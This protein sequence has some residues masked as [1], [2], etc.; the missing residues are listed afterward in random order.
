VIPA[1]D[2]S[3]A[4]RVPRRPDAPLQTPAP[5]RF[6]LP[7]K[8]GQGDE[9]ATSATP[10]LNTPR[11]AA[12]TPRREARQQQQ[13][14]VPAFSTPATA[15]SRP[16]P[17]RQW[18]SDAIDDTSPQSSQIL[19]VH[20]SEDD[21]IE[22]DSQSQA[23]AAGGR[24]PKR[25]RLSLSPGLEISS[26]VE[27]E[28]SGEQEQASDDELFP[29]E[30]EEPPDNP[31]FGYEANPDPALPKKQP[32]FHKAPRF[33]VSDSAGSDQLGRL[34]EAFS[35]QRRGI[36]YVPSGLAAELQDWL[37]KI[38][39]DEEVEG[40]FARR[41]VVTEVKPS[42]G[43]FLVKGRPVH[44]GAIAAAVPEIRAILAGD[45]RMDGLTRNQVAQGSI[46]GIAQPTWDVE[47]DDGVPWIVACDWAVA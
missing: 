24:S 16:R 36:R 29:S 44:D 6:L 14:Q 32:T 47:L 35:P 1:L 45:G 39:G 7:R 23:D 22:A 4:H 5:S 12:S 9:A 28:A 27:V 30:D 38:K 42:P 18:T 25:I 19:G 17:S 41:L 15:A 40:G 34:P 2:C 3:D 13:Q 11:F 20:T 31:G 21:V 33:K 10:R 8:H 37:F 26:Q 46:V 43:M